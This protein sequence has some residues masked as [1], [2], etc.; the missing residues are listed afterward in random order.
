MADHLMGRH[1]AP[2]GLVL[3]SDLDEAE[4]NFLPILTAAERLHEEAR[5]AEETSLIVQ[6]VKP[7]DALTAFVIEA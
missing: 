2:S 7:C 6:E 4:E 1:L 3:G 5:R